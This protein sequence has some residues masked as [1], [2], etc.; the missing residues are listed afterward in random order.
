MTIPVIGA[1]S[2]RVQ[3]QADGKVQ[4]FPIPFPLAAKADLHV[5]VGALRIATGF[6]VTDGAAAMVH[7]V[8]PPDRGTVVTL[9][10]AMTL[11]RM[12]EFQE[13]G[14]L[15]AAALNDEFSRLVMMVQQVDEK[16]QR[17]F[18]VAPHA[19]AVDPVLPG[20]GPG[21]LRWNKAGTALELDTN[22]DRAIDAAAA[23]E[24]AQ[25][26][27]ERAAHLAQ[28]AATLRAGPA[29]LEGSGVV[30]RSSDGEWTQ[31]GV[32]GG[33]GAL[34]RLKQDGSLDALDGGL[35]S[36]LDASALSHGRIAMARLGA[37]SGD[38]NRLLRGDGTFIEA[39]FG[40]QP[41]LRVFTSSGTWTKSA[42]L[43]GI[44]VIVTGGGGGNATPSTARSEPGGGGGTAIKMI[45]ADALGASVTVTVGAGGPSGSD[46]GTS[47]FGSHL[48]A[49]GGKGDSSGGVGSGGDINLPGGIGRRW[50]GYWSDG[51][52]GY[53][54]DRSA[55]AGPSGASYW[56]SGVSLDQP[57][58]GPGVGA[59]PS[60]DSRTRAGAAGLVV[61]EEYY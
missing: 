23:A 61:I 5:F 7:F 24:A 47:S 45:N 15:R 44:K 4:D 37:T 50:S 38:A 52:G 16:A 59:G 34:L 56:A 31:I 28:N 39:Q 36:N 55:S 10:R 21:F 30:M 35:L 57:G 49:T 26:N 42:G 14:D 9:L 2:P 29:A 18:A 12:A 40:Q 60:S 1:L 17:A 58:N 19:A 13:G 32:T 27:A 6:H 22:I 33:D 54:F 51:Y 25:A 43:K 11:R 3:Y 20:P 8:A 46:G 48:S 41:Q 53:V